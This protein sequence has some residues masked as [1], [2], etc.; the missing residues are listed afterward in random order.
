MSEILVTA[1]GRSG[2]HAGNEDDDDDND[3]RL[4]SSIDRVCVITLLRVLGITDHFVGFPLDAT[5]LR[6]LRLL[7]RL[8][9][10]DGRRT[11]LLLLLRLLLIVQRGRTLRRRLRR[12]L[13]HAL[14]R[15]ARLIRRPRG[16]LVSVVTELSWLLIALLVDDVLESE[17]QGARIAVQPE[18]LL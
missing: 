10:T 15:Q 14:A 6:L 18:G 16:P 11:L 17:A 9:M 4:S 5:I 2:D 3:G 1:L 13:V 7:L 8:L 12:L